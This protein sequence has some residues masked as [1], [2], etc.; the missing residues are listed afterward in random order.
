MDGVESL[1]DKNLLRQIAQE[2]DEPRLMMLETIRE[3]GLEMLLTNGEM[4]TAGQSHA[5]Y[6]LG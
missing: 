3:Y 6:Y 4:T 5:I 2:E 1:I